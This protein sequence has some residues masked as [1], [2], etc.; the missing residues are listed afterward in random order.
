MN[1]YAELVSA[2]S[3]FLG[4]DGN[5]DVEA[6]V[7]VFVSLGED[8]IYRRLRHPFMVKNAAVGTVSPYTVPDD[9][10]EAVAVW[11]GYEKIEYLP[12]D[13]ILAS[14]ATSEEPTQWSVL[15][16][17]L[18]FDGTP[19]TVTTLSYY[20]KPDSLATS[21]NRLFLANSDLY[22]YAALTQSIPYLRNEERA[23]VWGQLYAK[24]LED[25]KLAAWDADRPHGQPMYST[26]R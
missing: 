21:T 20:A 4:Q 9:F 19:T 8:D 23:Q 3:A 5:P 22:L 16:E 7:P 11:N 26:L 2:V 12:A 25:L 15:G 13:R 6:M 1:T 18:I 24:K 14:E 10:L 17:E